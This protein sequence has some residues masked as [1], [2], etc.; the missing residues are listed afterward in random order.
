MVIFPILCS[1]FMRFSFKSKSKKQIKEILINSFIHRQLYKTTISQTIYPFIQNYQKSCPILPT[2][3]SPQSVA[4]NYPPIS[5]SSMHR[6]NNK[7][8]SSSRSSPTIANPPKKSPNKNQSKKQLDPNLS[9]QARCSSSTP[10]LRLQWMRCLLKCSR[11][12]P[13]RG[14]SRCMIALMIQVKINSSCWK[15]NLNARKT[16]LGKE[17][18]CL[19]N[20]PFMFIEDNIDLNAVMSQPNAVA[21]TL[22]KPIDNRIQ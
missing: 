6:K 13:S 12:G 5:T 18:S 8:S 1:V 3:T 21:N 19:R 2:P 15:T 11:K 10:C 22:G 20:V 4:S 16:S 17:N 14:L 7:L 9:P